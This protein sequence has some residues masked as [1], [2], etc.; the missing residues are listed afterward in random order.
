VPLHADDNADPFHHCD[1]RGDGA[2]CPS[3]EFLHANR[4][5]LRSEAHACKKDFP[6]GDY[7]WCASHSSCPYDDLLSDKTLYGWDPDAYASNK[8]L[9]NSGRRVQVETHFIEEKG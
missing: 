5:N 1:T 8:Y 2:M 4:W 9:I 7:T 3:F 6:D